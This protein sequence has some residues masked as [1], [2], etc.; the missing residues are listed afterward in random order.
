MLLNLY[1]TLVRPHLEYN[2]A[3][4]SPH[5]QK[6]KSLLE[7]VQHRFTRLFTNL[8][9]LPYETRLL[10]LGLWSLEDRRNRGDLLE[11]FKIIKG[12]TDVPWQTFSR[13][14]AHSTC[15]HSWKLAKQ[16]CNQDC[17]LHFF[18]LRVLNRWN[19]LTQELVD[20]ESVNSFKSGL[21]KLRKRK[22]GFLWTDV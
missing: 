2:M 17:R 8:R 14:E 20:S 16:T 1:K 3:A 10:R 21:E 7:R 18:S 12:F 22:M 13:N 19:S 5:Y 11:V 4:W 9:S 6:D 15:G